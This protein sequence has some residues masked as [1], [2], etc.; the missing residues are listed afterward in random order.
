MAIVEPLDARPFGFGDDLR[1]SRSRRESEAEQAKVA[2]ERRRAGIEAEAFRRGFEA[3]RAEGEARAAA[4]TERRAAEALET[5]AIQAGR[6][7]STI[8]A[9]AGIIERE[10]LIY[11]DTLARKLAGRALIEHPLAGIATAALEAFQ[12]LRG[13]PHLAA[14]VHESLVEAVEAKLRTMAREH[15]FEGR[16]VVLGSDDVPPGD[17][18]LEWADGGIVNDQRAVEQSV[19]AVLSRC[20]HHLPT[21]EETP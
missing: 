8:E 19:D 2:E 3:G 20:L 9:R 11:F 10:A 4:E 16:I 1:P 7:L 13:V 12:H 15:G 14:R 17:C 6:A 5:A 21:G 18:R